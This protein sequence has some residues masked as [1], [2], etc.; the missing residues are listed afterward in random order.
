VTALRLKEMGSITRKRKMIHSSFPICTC[1]C[2]NEDVPVE[3]PL[4]RV[5]V[6]RVVRVRVRVRRIAHMQSELRCKM[7][8][9]SYIARRSQ[10]AHAHV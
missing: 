4:K 3:L 2:V 1:T 7:I 5:R 9:S 8:H 6:L 10:F